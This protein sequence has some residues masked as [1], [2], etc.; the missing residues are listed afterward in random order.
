VS[1]TA[2]SKARAARLRRLS[3]AMRQNLKRRKAQVR[4]RAVSETRES[5]GKSG[6]AAK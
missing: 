1:D 6:G 2:K 4:G 3:A 5:D